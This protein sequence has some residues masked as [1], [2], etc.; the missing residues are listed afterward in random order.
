MLKQTGLQ[1]LDRA[2]ESGEPMQEKVG[3]RI[4]GSGLSNPRL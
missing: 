1:T 4:V 3:A 2:I